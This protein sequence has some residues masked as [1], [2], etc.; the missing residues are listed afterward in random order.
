MYVSFPLLSFNE[1]GH[2]KLRELRVF[3][4]VFKTQV[5]CY[6]HLPLPIQ[7]ACD[8]THI[9]C[10]SVETAPRI[11]GHNPSAQAG[12]LAYTYLQGVGLNLAA[13]HL[14][15]AFLPGFGRATWEK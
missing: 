13:T 6:P 1:R 10:M 11:A 2:V 4:N 7:P 15:R 9:Q 12:G 3:K 5:R 14:A 8:R